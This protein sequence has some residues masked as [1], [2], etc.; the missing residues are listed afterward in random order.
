MALGPVLGSILGSTS[1]A[2]A[3]AGEG[4]G[5]GAAF[6]S[7]VGR[8]SGW[9]G[10]WKAG[11]AAGAGFGASTGTGPGIKKTNKGFTSRAAPPTGSPGGHVCAYYQHKSKLCCLIG[12][13]ALWPHGCF[14]WPCFSCVVLV[15][16]F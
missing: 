16:W 7:V 1:G 11:F 2:D 10:S 13:S 5:E 15:Y 12:G 14:K 3:A 4:A 9:K 8:P 6:G